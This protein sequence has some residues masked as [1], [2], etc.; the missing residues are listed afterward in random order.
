MPAGCEFTCK[1]KNCQHYQAG[2]SITGNWPIAY[3]EKVID[4]TP[5]KKVKD[6]R[7]RLISLKEAGTL[8]ALIQFPNVDKLPCVG[9]RISLWS[10]EAHR[11]WNYEVDMEGKPLVEG[12]TEIPKICE[13]TGCTL[14]TFNEVVEKGIECPFCKEKLSQNRWFVNED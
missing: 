4:S 2:F 3:I 13:K 5:V 7:E 12:I 14:L 10:P 6:L 1:N 9:Q 8:Y 11:I